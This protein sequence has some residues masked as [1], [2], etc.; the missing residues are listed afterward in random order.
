[1]IEKSI[2]IDAGSTKLAASLCTPKETGKFPMVLLIQGSGNA[3][4]NDN[5]PSSKNQTPKASVE[6]Y[7]SLGF[8][9]LRYDK[10]GVAESGGD[11]Y[12]A[13]HSDLV[14]DAEFA[15]NFLY[16]NENCDINN[17]FLVGHSEGALISCCIAKQ[18]K[19]LAGIVLLCPVYTRVEDTLIKQAE[20]LS[21]LSRNQKGVLGLLF[22]TF[23]CFYD[24]VKGQRKF[25]ERIRKSSDDVIR[26]ML[27]KTPA[28]WYREILDIEP[29]DLYV[30]V[31]CPALVIG[32]SKDMQCD[33]E[34]IQRIEQAVSGPVECHLIK[35][36]THVLRKEPGDMALS[37]NYELLKQ[38]FDAE[39]K[40]II[41]KWIQRNLVRS[42]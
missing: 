17:I 15:L 23:F 22:R 16:N 11:F 9:S 31:D 4:R 8:G 24:P 20:N 41:G 32:G 25:N 18:N 40:E 5:S 33:P 36:L 13:G 35:D 30:N 37:T 12:S 19:Y 14:A 7:N 29:H 39:L 2:Q 27:M 38:P 21:T 6:F 10:R 1:M 26:Y 28:K 3:D 34:D 42:P